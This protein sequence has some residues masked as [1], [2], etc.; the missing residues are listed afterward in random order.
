MY[1]VKGHQRMASAEK[2]FNNSVDIGQPPSQAA[3]VITQWAHEQSGHG[4]RD[5][6]YAWVQQ[7]GLPFTKANLT[8]ATAKHPFWDHSSG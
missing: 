1:I 4:G 7:H 3:P 5:G 8:M 2:D 6:G